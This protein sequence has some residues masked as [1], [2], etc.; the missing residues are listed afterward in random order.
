M[1][2]LPY[3]LEHV[4]SMLRSYQALLGRP[5][6]DR[7]DLERT[8]RFLYE[9]APFC[10][11]AHSAEPEPRFVY[12]NLTALRCFEYTR[13]E[14]LG[15]PSRLSAEPERREERQRFVHEV[16]ARGYA[17]GYRGLR[18]AKSGRRFWIED[19]TMWNLVDG[20]G[21]LCG[22]AATYGRITPA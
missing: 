20:R 13:E 4:R 3:D 2:S 10:L 12:A 11:L 8:A 21:V 1:S 7:G 22:Q 16:H 5:L 15:L 6:A 9:D 17:E 14:L 18:I 19:V